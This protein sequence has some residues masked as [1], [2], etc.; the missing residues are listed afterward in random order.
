MN[1]DRIKFAFMEAFLEKHGENIVKDI[2]EGIRYNQ[3]NGT[4]YMERNTT[5]SVDRSRNS[6]GTLHIEG[7]VYERFQDILASHKHKQEKKKNRKTLRDN[8]YTPGSR[9]GFY[10]KSIYKHITPIIW[11]LAYGL[12]A[13]VRQNIKE[14]FEGCVV[15]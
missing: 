2:Q 13:E 14:T 12:T 8:Q 1:D 10:T 15:E 5:F 6:E 11:D 9:K 4:G 7:P 3:Y